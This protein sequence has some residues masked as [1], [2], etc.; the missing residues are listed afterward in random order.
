MPEEIRCLD[1]FH[2]TL[3]TYVMGPLRLTA[4]SNTSFP[5][6]D[7]PL[8]SDESIELPL[9][10][11]ETGL[12]TCVNRGSKFSRLVEGG[13][14]AYVTQDIMTRAPV[15]EARDVKQALE[16]SDYIKNNFEELKTI[17]ESTT[18]HG[19]ALSVKPYLV[20]NDVYVRLIMQTG[21]ASGHNM[22]TKSGTKLVRYLVE[23]FPGALYGSDSGNMCTDKKAAA[24][25]A[26]T[27]RGKSVIT[28]MTIP[29][30]IC[31][32]YLKT[33]PEAIE[34]LNTMKNL[35]GS[36]AAGSQFSA[37]AHYANIIAAMYIST[38]QDIANIVE[39]SYGITQAKVTASGDL[40]FSTTHPCLIVG[41][42]G[43]GKNGE[44]QR[45]SLEILDCLQ[46]NKPDG[47]NSQRLAAIIAAATA[48]GELSLLADQTKNGRLMD[49][50][51]RFER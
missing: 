9:S 15:L 8:A 35:Q 7:E 40:Y 4:V 13:V 21:E 29:R 36:I 41:T 18:S 23:K 48:M 51:E 6:I 34:R 22:T 44:S 49:A 47:F 5:I 33:T 46:Q 42:I 20:G 3:D 14:K 12:Y 24:I 31:E 30:E 38:G 25:N 11:Y 37:N 19:K 16:I 45:K 1:K 26:I 17:A 10:T 32:K 27:G 28:E 2:T 50:H 43:N 39:G